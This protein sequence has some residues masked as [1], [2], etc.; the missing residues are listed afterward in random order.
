MKITPAWASAIKQIG[1][2]I[3]LVVLGYFSDVANLEPLFGASASAVI[4]VVIAAIEA[5]IKAETG[6]ALFGAAR[7]R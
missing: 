1:L 2:L 7:V 3:L 6:Q 5:K 4:V